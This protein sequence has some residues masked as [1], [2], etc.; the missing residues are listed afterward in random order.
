METKETKTLIQFYNSLSR[1]G[2][3]ELKEFWK[4]KTGL[5]DTSF[6]K[7]FRKPKEEDKE[8]AAEFSKRN[9]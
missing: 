9:N 7:H 4:E 6:F 5:S 8:I 2:Q 1:S 3:I